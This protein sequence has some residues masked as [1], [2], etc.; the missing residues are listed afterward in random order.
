VVRDSLLRVVFPRFSD[1][2]VDLAL[3]L[4]SD[5]AE[6]VRIR[7]LAVEFL[8]RMHHNRALVDL[9][10]A[11]VETNRE[12]SFVAALALAR[13]R[14]FFGVPTLLG[15]LG[16]DGKRNEELRAVAA[17]VLRQSTGFDAG[18]RA[19]GTPDARAKAI[20]RWRDWWSKNEAELVRGSYLVLQK[21]AVLTAARRDAIELWK[22]AHKLLA[23][24]KFGQGEAYL[25]KAVETD[26]TFARGLLS[27]AILLYSHDGGPPLPPEAPEEVREQREELR[28]ARVEEAERVLRGMT[29]QVLPDLET[30]D[31]FRIHFEL[32][33]VLLL[34]SNPSEALDEFETAFALDSTSLRSVLGAAECHWQLATRRNE[35]TT[36]ERRIEAQAAL[37]S[38]EKSIELLRARLRSIR[39]L[40]VDELPDLDALPFRRGEHNRNV[41]TIRRELERRGVRLRMRIARAYTF[42]GDRIGAIKALKEGLDDLE[43]SFELEDA[44]QLEAELRTFLARCYEVQGENALALAEYAK[45][46]RELDPNNAVCRRGIGRLERKGLRRERAESSD[47][48]G[49]RVSRD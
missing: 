1:E 10:N 18:F 33:N 8:R 26:P 3:F 43:A 28:L 31:R 24:E 14:I 16:L 45:V 47:G 27:L 15:A 6:S 40:G 25:R 23:D 44:N 19:A 36:P 35:L 11:N 21:R 34:R 2:S 7:G 48:A 13:N 30:E 20:D 9:H 37:R 17:Q 38:Y 29:D 39:V 41:L 32:G 4:I 49:P 12:L 22:T 42:K 46:I 5:P